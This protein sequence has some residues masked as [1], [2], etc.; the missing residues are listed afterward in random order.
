MKEEVSRGKEIR[1]IATM[2][3]LALVLFSSPMTLA[4]FASTSVVASCSVTVT[5]ENI[6]NNAVQLAITAAEA[7]LTGPVVCVASGIYPEELQIT[8]SGIALRGLGT[9]RNPTVIQ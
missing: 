1:R 9:Y 4:T 8:S 2:A 5:G 7:H 6:G 3:L